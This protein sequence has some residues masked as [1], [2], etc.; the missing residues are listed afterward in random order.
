LRDELEEAVA[1]AL[2]RRGTVM[3][4]AAGRRRVW[5]A[6]HVSVEGEIQVGTPPPVRTVFR[7][8]D[9]PGE[10]ALARMGFRFVFDT[11]EAPLGGG[12]SARARAVEVMDAALFDVHGAEREHGIERVLQQPGA[13]QGAQQ[14]PADAP[15]DEHLRA[16]VTALVAAGRG[17]ARF[18]TGRP[19]G[20]RA[21]AFTQGEQLSIEDIR[22]AGAQWKLP[23]QPGVEAEAAEHLATVLDRAGRTAGD[24]LYVAL[25]D[26]EG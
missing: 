5:V 10:E 21:W 3:L 2:A 19:A 16:A 24:P 23:L 14:P 6:V 25:M 8:R 20:A 9:E 13:V 17:S 26:V 15:H 1:D 7:F 18:D 12:A 22:P 11:W 4:Q